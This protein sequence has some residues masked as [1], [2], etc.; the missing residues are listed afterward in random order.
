MVIVQLAG[1]LGNQ[2]Y[3]YGVGKYFSCQLNTEL[4]IDILSYFKGKSRADSRHTHD[5]YELNDFNIEENYA[6]PEEIKRVRENGLIFNSSSWPNLNKFLESKKDIYINGFPGGEKYI[7]SV[8]N[9][10]RK[11]FTLK[12]PLSLCAETYKKKILSAEYPVSMHFRYG[13]CVYWPGL[14]G[15]GKRPWMRF[16]PISYYQ[17]AVKVLK[18]LH[19]NLTVFVFSNDLQFIKENLCSDVPIEFIEGCKSATEEL[20]LMSLCKCNISPGSSFS[21]SAILL[22]SNPDKIFIHA[23]YTTDEEVSKYFNSLTTPIPQP[24]VFCRNTIFVPANFYEQKKITIHPFFSLLLVVNND[25]NTIAETLNS[26]LNQYY[27]YY[28]VIIIDNASTDGSEK[29]CQQAI[30]GKENVTFLKLWTKVKNAEAWN[31][32][33]SMTRWR[34]SSYVS[35]LKGN[36]RFLANAFTTLY[37]VNASHHLDIVN[38]FAYLT[39]NESGN[40][41]FGDKKY[42]EQRD[43]K[44][45]AAK[46]VVMS[47]DGKDAAK[48]LLNQQINRFLGTKIYNRAFLTDNKIKFDEHLADDEAEL[49]F[50]MEC[51]LKSKYF[52][53]APNAVY[54]TPSNP[55]K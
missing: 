29:I 46:N 5:F 20:V 7:N 16:T 12:N 13:D 32:A 51:F 39:E 42:S 21:K 36:D 48:L 28:E 40:V 45:I 18:K 44:F 38:S 19:N 37:L 8:M 10:L 30:T 15:Y 31:M 43:A 24:S 26:I 9:V 34:G 27:K 33:L 55:I 6:T 4:K 54:I 1:G 3:E 17:N 22:N 23:H 2:V 50:Q 47:Q 49:Y 11:E 25:A 41:T 52:M 14:D 53:Y 35:F